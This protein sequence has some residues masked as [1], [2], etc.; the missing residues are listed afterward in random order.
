MSRAVSRVIAF[1]LVLV[2]I[3]LA[4]YHGSNFRKSHYLTTGIVI[5]CDHGGRGN[6]GPGIYYAYHIDN[7]YSGTG[8][9]RHSDLP[10]SIGRAIVGR[11]FPVAYRKYWYGY[12]ESILITPRDFE[13]YGH[14]FPDTLKWIL[15]Y[16]K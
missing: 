2:A 12:E 10:Y 15:H 5:R 1:V 13:L 8:S 11:S 16:M 14:P 9:V 6:F 4:V 3:L 7:E